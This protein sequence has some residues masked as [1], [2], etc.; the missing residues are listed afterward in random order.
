MYHSNIF[1]KS[2]K[3]VCIRFYQDKVDKNSEKLGIFENESA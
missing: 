2:N 3:N 1:Y